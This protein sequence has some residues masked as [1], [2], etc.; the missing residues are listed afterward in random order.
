MNYTNINAADIARDY[1]FSSI[2]ELKNHLQDENNLVDGEIVQIA[3]N[4]GTIVYYPSIDNFMENNYTFKDFT[5]WIKYSLEIDT[6]N[7]KFLFLESGEAF[8]LTDEEFDLLED[9]QSE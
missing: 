5:H 7:G 6:V 1:L 3:M 2:E 4:D 8:E 9:L